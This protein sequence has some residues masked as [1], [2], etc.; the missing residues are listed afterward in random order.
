MLRLSIIYCTEML[1]CKKNVIIGNLL[2]DFLK[3][4]YYEGYKLMLIVFILPPNTS[5]T[6][7]PCSQIVRAGLASVFE[8]L[9]PFSC[10][11]TPFAISEWQIVIKSSG[12]LFLSVS[13]QY[14]IIPRPADIAKV[15]TY[16][17][18]SSLI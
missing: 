6:T 7:Q 4:K 16:S 3:S 2:R 5:Q 1:I 12:E 17:V 11:N 13:Y 8:N 10:P 14:S 9:Y 15:R 18:C